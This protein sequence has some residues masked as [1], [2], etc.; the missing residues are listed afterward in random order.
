MINS[1]TLNNSALTM[2]SIKKILIVDDE[3]DICY[4]LSRNLSKRGFAATVACTLAD[5]ERQLEITRPHILLLDNHLPDGRGIDFISKINYKYPDLKIIMITAH[6]S[7]EDRS[8]AYSRGIKYF[9][10]KPF[11]MATINQVIDL[12]I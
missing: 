1:L 9:L 7:L 6:D 12:V 3:E 2:P 8:K 4:F 11:S 5:A 10:S